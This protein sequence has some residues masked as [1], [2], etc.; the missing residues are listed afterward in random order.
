MSPW[1]ERLGQ[2]ATAP[3]SPAP[4][5]SSYE[6]RCAEPPEPPESEWHH[7]GEL[8]LSTGR[9]LEPPNLYTPFGRRLG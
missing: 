3:S 8:D 2:G 1:W 9:W 6:Q 5:C 7:I 4:G